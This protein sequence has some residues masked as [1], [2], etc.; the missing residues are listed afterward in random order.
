MQL[1]LT[2]D[3]EL[4]AKTA[5]D[6][7]AERSP[8]SRVRK[9]R[10]RDDA[11]GFSR[12]LW[13]E[14]AELGWVGIPFPESVGGAGMGLAELCVVMEALGRT[15]APEPF[16]STVLLGGQALLLGGSRAQQE[17]W[18]ARVVA[19]EALLS[20]AWQERRSR[21][22]LTRVETRAEPAA[23]GFRLSGE[24]LHVPDGH[25]ADALVVAARGPRDA[26]I[27]LF[28]VERGAPGLGVERQHRVD[29]RGAA[30]LRLEGVEVDAGAVVGEP[31]GG[32]PLLER[33]IDRATV[34][35]CAEMLGSMS[36]AFSRTLAYLKDRVQF[37][38]PI[39]SFQA[40]KHRAAQMFIEIELCRSSVMA[41]A[42][43]V[44]AGEPEAPK[45]VSLAK[46]RCSDTAV[47][48]ANESIQMHGGIGMTDEHD[49]GFYLKR[50]RVAATTFGD[51][52][53]HRAR[54]ARLAGY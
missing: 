26:G 8:V 15:L 25:V 38:V 20:L 50:A 29:G 28:L 52:A 17:G 47:L 44:D 34:G 49:I 40:L 24:K 41:A 9:L 43:A 39:G 32:L 36:E 37:G 48:V 6:F 21:Y 33:V 14:M 10:D 31:G 18:L 16:L 1:V 46:A 19:G 45:L 4:L 27:G 30:R 35:L 7:V 54:W 11:V 5:A 2:E 3:Q 23:G 53:V 22:D 51:A 13:R 42:R 12:E